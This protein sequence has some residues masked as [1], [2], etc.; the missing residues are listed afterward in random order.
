MGVKA[1]ADRPEIWPV[2]HRQ[3]QYLRPWVSIRMTV[4]SRAGVIHTVLGYSKHLM[5]AAITVVTA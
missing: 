4:I 2:E 1:E 3:R 5:V